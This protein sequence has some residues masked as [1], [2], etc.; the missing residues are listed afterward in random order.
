MPKTVWELTRLEAVL[1]AML[2]GQDGYGLEL[3]DRA[4]DVGQSVSL[5]SLYTTLQRLEDA[6]LIRS[7]WGAST[8]VRRGAR[9]RYYRLTG[10]GEQALRDTKQ[11]WQ[12]VL[13]LNKQEGKGSA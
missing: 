4:E 8:G 7:R 1:L 11:V 9:R 10:R 2:R 6:G 5:A 13:R 3:R 12:R